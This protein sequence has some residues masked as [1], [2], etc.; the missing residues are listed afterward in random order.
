MPIQLIEENEGNQINLLLN[1]T[2]FPRHRIGD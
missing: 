1:G 2:L